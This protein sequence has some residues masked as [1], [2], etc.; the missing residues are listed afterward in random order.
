[1]RETGRDTNPDEHAAAFSGP[2]PGANRFV[3]TLGSTGLRIAFLEEANGVSYFRNAITLHP[4]DGL[5]LRNLLA[6]ML[7]DV[8]KQID[9]L[10]AQQNNGGE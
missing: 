10:E 4:Q 2:A 5:R 7:A 8:E 6:R 3:L 9:K 1:M